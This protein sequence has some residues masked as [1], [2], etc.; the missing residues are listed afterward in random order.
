M[1]LTADLALAE[2]ALNALEQIEARALVWGLVDNALGNEEVHDTLNHVL[3]DERNAVLRNDVAC[4]IATARDLRDQ[5]VALGM[6][7][8]VP[9]TDAGSSDDGPRWRTRMAEGV[10]LIARLRQLFPQH[11]GSTQ[12]AMAPTLVAD[13]RFLR[14]ARRYPKRDQQREAVMDVIDDAV[15]DPALL[16]A[17]A[18][19]LDQLP[20][21][22]GLSRFQVDAAARILGGL[23]QHKRAGTLVS[24]GTGSGKTLAF[25]LPALAWLAQ[26]RVESPKASVRVLALYPRNELLKDQLAEVYEQ[27]RKF[28]DWTASRGGAALRVGVL[29]G[30]TPESR[31]H[32]LKQRGW[33]F[34]ARESICP[35]FAC[36]MPGCG[37]EMVVREEDKD[38]PKDRLVC[39]SCGHS[40][41]SDQLA[42]TRKAMADEPPDILFTSVEMLNRHLSN[43]KLRHLFGV[44]PKAMEAPGLVLMDEVHLYSGT[45]GAQVAYLMRRWWAASGRRSSF[46]GLSATISEGRRFFASLTGLDESVVQEIKPLEDDIEDEGAE[47][48]LALRGDPVSQAA[49]LSTTI[50]TLML[51]ARL[52]DLRERFDKT[53]NPFFGWRA[54][55]FTDQLDAA[56]RLFR[57]LQDA[58]GRHF[59][60]SPNVVRHRDGGLARLRHRAEPPGRRYDAGQDW[61]VAE[62]IGHEL[63]TRLEVARTTAYDSGVSSRSEV[64]VATAALEVGFD[65]PAVGVV[66]QHKAPRDV[67]SFLQRKGRAGRT[68][69][70]RPWTM[71]VLTDYGRDRI[72]YQAYDTLFDPE[73][74]ARQLPL[75]NRYVQ[76][77]QSVYAL[78]D[79]LG[80]MT[81]ADPLAI[82]VWRDMKGPPDDS[83]LAYWDE[84]NRRALEKL[85]RKV[86]VEAL[87]P[88]WHELRNEALQLA[89]QDRGKHMKLSGVYWLK[90]RLVHRRLHDV[91]KR[92]LTRQEFADRLAV[93]L[94]KRL[95][96]S[97]EDMDV[98]LWTQPRPVLLGAVPTAMRRLQMN[99]QGK[100]ADHPDYIAE[101]PLPD[102]IPAN[103]FD[104]LSLPEMRLALPG[105]EDD[106]HYLPVQQGLGEFAPG[107]VSRRFDDALW[108]GV[109]A[110]TLNG[111]LGMGQDILNQDADVAEWYETQGE[112]PFHRLEDGQVVTY[113]AFQPRTARLQAAPG[114]QAGLP[115]LND[116][117]NAQLTWSSHLEAPRDGIEFR[118]PEYMGVS[119][120]I[121][122]VTA[123]THAGQSAALVRRYAV[124]SRADMRMRIGNESHRLTVNWRFMHEGQSCG[125][126]F[127]IDADA[128]LIV[129]NLPPELHKSIDWSDEARARAARAARYNWEA[130]HCS[131]FVAAVANPFLRGWIAQIFQI[132]AILVATKE[133]LSLRVALDEVANGAR[134]DVLLGVL[135]T[136]FQMPE[137]EAGDESPD[138]LRLSLD[139]ALHTEAVRQA[140][141][142][143]ARVLVSPIDAEWDAWLSQTVRATLGAACLEAIQQACP[144][145]DPDGLIVDID[146]GI[147]MDGIASERAEIWISETSPGGNG[148]IEQVVELLASRSDSFYKHVEAALESSD[149]EST[150]TQL[151]QL[152]RWIGGDARDAELVAAV[153]R[154]RNASSPTTAQAEFARL[155]AELVRR[156]QA[157]FHGYAVALSLR[158]LRPESPEEIDRLIAE[159]HGHWESLEHTHG[160]EIDVRVMCAVHS[161]G[162]RLDNAFASS[163]LILPA[164]DRES[165]RF[166]VLMGLL[167]PQGHALRAVNLPLSNRFV[168]AVATERLLLGQWLTQRQTPID[169][170]TPGWEELARE[171][172]VTRSEAVFV[173]V[174]SQAREI[175]PTLIRTLTIEPIHFDYL[176]VFAMLSSVKRR[177]DTIELQFSISESA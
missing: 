139:E 36:P 157:V 137:T 2:R 18:H 124:A 161:S 126:G 119:R 111:Y 132:A 129:L 46:V 154:V 50:Q 167:W 83:R 173:V 70:M 106:G 159:I 16:S 66:V 24:A 22:A 29:Y 63:T 49:L 17:V 73:L 57:N 38:L 107:K 104:D 30:E 72:A 136:V 152:V 120:L 177:D 23:T 43:P 27:C 171:Q 125:V 85:V 5:L 110:E 33:R 122:S 55:A 168:P 121:D 87:T 113:R 158:M 9:N 3:D 12:W 84:R 89:P 40:V 64:V 153:I 76:R 71:I 101:H 134:M 109:S 103:L 143:A 6:L 8:E 100:D 26:Q 77:M 53:R 92:F 91:L 31:Q 34:N 75:S 96:I 166:G 145:V 135:S 4:N 42:F 13:Y 156:G 44:G 114:R 37:G 118:P 79:V 176:N 56:N 60:G 172:L 108:L 133:Q 102:Y 97:R 105:G 90:A 69:H 47:Y 52:L 61:R 169:P 25:Y 19:W 86:P 123:H 155:R 39:K 170:T 163:G 81:Q 28:D 20:P 138:R 144:Q 131:S 146:P 74:P 80:D 141:R 116:T 10:R 147:R 21:N 11:A 160:I 128:L 149:V 54:F 1:A 148:M 82:Q 32:A 88:A 130:Q 175:V 94:Q 98:L 127:E 35:F 68:R 142:D 117:S 162:T 65:D 45:Y 51:A 150:N 78:L 7:F 41:Q 151:K 67:A 62:D 48:L 58:E 93:S 165:W 174:A 14:R 115:E 164:N 15:T 112:R 95:A 140:V 59:N 99:W